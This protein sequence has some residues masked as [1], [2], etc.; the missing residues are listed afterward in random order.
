MQKIYSFFLLIFPSLFSAVFIIILLLL[1]S[2]CYTLKQ[3][4]TML[5]YLG[6]AVPLEELE[7]TK[8]KESEEAAFVKQV[9]DIRRFAMEELGLKASKNYTRYVELDRN[10][11]A[12]V[13]SACAADSFT[14]HEWTFPVVG[15]VPYKGFFN[16]KD[17]QKE[18]SKLKAEGL[19]VWIRPVDAF[20]TLG[21][22]KDPLY[23]YMKNYSVYQLADLII[24]EL[25]HAT[26]F[27][28]GRV[29][30]NEQLAEFVG[31]HGAR[32]YIINRFG[33]N[34]PEYLSISDGEDD[35]RVFR[36][37]LF[38]LGAELQNL[39]SR[40]DIKREE[41]LIQKDLIIKTAQERFE[42]EYKS[43]FQSDKYRG[44]SKM[45]INNAYLD[46]YRL[47]HEE[48]NFFSDLYKKIPIEDDMQKLQVLITAAAALN[49]SREARKDPRAELQKQLQFHIM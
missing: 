28:K 21:W 10:Y 5:G 47:Y 24:H 45:P 2:G 9:T 36:E 27:V 3:G 18:A 7:K 12:A 38:K 49:K 14:R 42:A 22:F 23:S 44:F 48:D 11:L 46:L 20:S 26:A 30:F 13:V 39:Y 4:T 29:E 33:I 25:F 6:K 34:S 8:G 35:Y 1:L 40:N 17:A 15:T 19:D 41:K 37:F 31:T 32:L 43:R 16:P